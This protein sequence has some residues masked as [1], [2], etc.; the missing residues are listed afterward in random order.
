VREERHY[1][2]ISGAPFKKEK[3]GPSESFFEWG[4]AEDRRSFTPTTKKK[5]KDPNPCDR[6]QTEGKYSGGV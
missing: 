2:S 4:G 5:Q 6:T 3:Q 1:Q